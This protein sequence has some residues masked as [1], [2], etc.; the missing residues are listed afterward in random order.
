MTSKKFL[1]FKGNVIPIERYSDG[2]WGDTEGG[3]YAVSEQTGAVDLV[4]RC[5]VGIFSLS[6]KSS[7]TAA[8]TPHD[9]A[10][11]SAAYQMFHTRK[12][13]DEYL[14]RLLKQLPGRAWLAKPFY[15]LTRLFGRFLWE[16]DKT[17]E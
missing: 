6:P 14:A 11:S 16:N 10:Y 3:L 12:E 1:V 17:N 2:L 13:A 7:A 4:A 5:G 8:C 9:F 15:Y